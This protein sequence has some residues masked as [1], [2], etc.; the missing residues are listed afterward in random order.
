[1]T[2]RFEVGTKEPVD[3]PRKLFE[4]MREDAILAVFVS[5]D[6]LC[7]EAHISV[8]NMRMDRNVLA[9]FTAFE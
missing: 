5:A 1:M 4:L 8:R 2:K 3:L 9:K 7:L 6:R